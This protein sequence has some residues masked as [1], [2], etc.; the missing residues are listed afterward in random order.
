MTKPRPK[1]DQKK[2]NKKI[3][4]SDFLT[5]E[6]IYTQQMTYYTTHTTHTTQHTQHTHKK[7]HIAVNGARTSDPKV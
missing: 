1:L 7:I 2:M 4:F 5:V 6:T 3:I